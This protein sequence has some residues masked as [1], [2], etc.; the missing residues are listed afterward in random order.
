MRV[1]MQD[2]EEYEVCDAQE[3]KRVQVRSPTNIR[4]N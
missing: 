1:L 2:E 4:S 3:F